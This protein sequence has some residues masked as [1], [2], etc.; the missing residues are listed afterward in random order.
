MSHLRYAALAVGLAVAVGAP[1]RADEADAKAA[2]ALVDKAIKA[3]GGADALTKF[4]ASTSK[5]KGTF[6]GMGMNL[7]MEGSLYANGADQFKV[8]IQ[9][10]AGGM[11]LQVTNVIDGDKGWAKVGDQVV[12][13]NAD[14]LAEARDQ[15]YAGWL[16]TLAPLVKG[17][18][19]TLATAG[20]VLVNDK[21]ALG[22]KVSHKGRGDVTLYFDKESSLLVKYE[23]KVKDEGSGQEV[24][25]EGFPSAY[26]EVQG[27]K[28]AMKFKT[29]R[30]SKLYLEGEISE[31]TLSDKLDANT[32]AK[33]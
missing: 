12:E 2:R 11:T 29:L 28:Q 14:Q 16:V 19:F 10:E 24:N 30:D 31:M 3:H 4:G 23:T 33:P 13:L 25:E 21:P 26:K 15:A 9:I 22:V 32:F 17:K 7:P 18:D 27:T 6:H 1:A 5:F 8:D 20:E